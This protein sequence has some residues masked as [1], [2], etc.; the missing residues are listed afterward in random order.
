LILALQDEARIA[1]HEHPLF[2][3]I[4]QENGLVTR[5]CPPVATQL[6]GPMA[7]GATH[8]PDLAYEVGRATG[9]CLNY[10]GINMNYAPVC[11]IN[12]EPLNPVIGVRSPGDDPE[13][14]GQFASAAAHGLRKQRIIPS[15]KH[16]PGHGE[17][18]VDSHYGL[19]VI[20]KTRDQLERCEL[21]PFRRTVAEGVESVMT[22]HIA[23]PAIGDGKLP[24]TLSADALNILRKDMKY[25]GMIV[26][27][28]LEMNGI[29][30]TYGTEQ[31]SVLALNAGSDSVMIC[32]THAVQMASIDRVCQAV[33][34]GGMSL[35][36][37]D[38]AHRRVTRLKRTFL[39]WDTALHSNP[40]ADL[41]SFNQQSAVLAKE[42]YSRSA[43]LVRCKPD[44][45][46]LSKSSKIVFLFPG[47]NTPAGGAVDGEGLGRQGSYD[48]TIYGDVIR[49][50]NQFVIEV[51]Y[52]PSGLSAEQWSLVESADVV[53]LTTVNARESPYQENLG[54]ELP[55]RARSLV[56]I[57]AC[58]PY[59]FL[60]HQSIETY[61]VTYEPTIDAFEAAADVIFGASSGKG[62]LPVGP[63][64]SAQPQAKVTP[65][66]AGDVEKLATIWNAALPTYHMSTERLRILVVQ[67]RAHH[68]VARVDSTLVGFCLAYTTEN[69]GKTSGQ[70]AALAVDHK[71]QGQGIG[72][73]LLTE[74]RAYFRNQFGLNNI[75]LGSAFPRFW[76]G[77]PRDLPDKIQ[78]FFVHRGFR[79]NPPG[80]RSVDLYQE[81]KDFQAPEKYITRAKERGYTFSPLQ[82]EHHEAC[83]AAQKKNFPTYTVSLHIWP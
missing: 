5:I 73:A 6:P 36:R 67:E 60:E 68:F 1:G 46:P 43:T 11:D 49:R 53:I 54:L 35:S 64:K 82:D 80:D 81:I 37:L 72:T 19:P 70:I 69:Q 47:A 71:Y 56:A 15:S 41:T 61:V 42:A 13:L 52:G 18:A 75:A 63:G 23:L 79:L 78:D 30:A 22:A 40:V 16:F 25:D 21:V 76:P 4:D 77:I 45:V 14:V 26:T 8:S 74:T 7:L 62:K 17:T 44:V 66:D 34:S 50:H 10:F 2:I 58:N 51:R 28:C 20:P 12:S 48:A 33:Q 9:E 39:N 83:M 59:D 65:F 32:H 29:R 27:D 3:G 24:A 55:N 57:A 31:G 38:E